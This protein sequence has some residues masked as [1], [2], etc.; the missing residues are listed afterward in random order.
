[1]CLSNHL[2]N[3]L[4]ATESIWRCKSL[5]L[6]LHP[7]TWITLELRNDRKPEGVVKSC[8]KVDHLSRFTSVEGE[9]SCGLSLPRVSL[10]F[11]HERRDGS[12]CPLDGGWSPTF[13]APFLGCTP[14][15]TPHCCFPCIDD[16]WLTAVTDM[17]DA[18]VSRVKV[19]VN[20]SFHDTKE[21]HFNVPNE[22]FWWW[23]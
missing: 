23:G 20:R 7:V 12:V 16:L 13:G 5:L 8:N 21:N 18:C 10:A 4:R 17:K 1:M 11:K 19:Q 15:L 22:S 14:V 9:N 2:L 6:T 3:V